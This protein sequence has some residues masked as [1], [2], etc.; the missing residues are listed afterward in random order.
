MDHDS[1][2]SLVWIDFQVANNLKKEWTKNVFGRVGWEKQVYSGKIHVRRKYESDTQN[3]GLGVSRALRGNGV[4]ST[5]I[6]ASRIIL[7]QLGVKT[8]MFEEI[9]DFVEKP[10][11]SL[12]YQS[13]GVHFFDQVGERGRFTNRPLLVRKAA[14]PTEETPLRPFVLR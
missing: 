3:C 9:V 1:L 2:D 5:L 4:A 7:G 10:D 12:F 8:L 14:I 6:T 11:T 13:L